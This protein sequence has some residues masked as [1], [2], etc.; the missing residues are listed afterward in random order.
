MNGQFGATGWTGFSGP[1]GPPG[2]PGPPGQVGPVGPQGFPGMWPGWQGETLCVCVFE[3]AT[4]DLP[5]W[6]FTFH[7][8]FTLYNGTKEDKCQRK[9]PSTAARIP[10]PFTRRS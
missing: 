4:L 6:L 7:I 2:I 9:E 1:N 5:I 10:E 8:T 3:K